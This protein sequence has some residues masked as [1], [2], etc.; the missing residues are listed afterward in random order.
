MFEMPLEINGTFYSKEILFENK[1]YY[2]LLF[3]R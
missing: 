2:Q 3:K 1:E